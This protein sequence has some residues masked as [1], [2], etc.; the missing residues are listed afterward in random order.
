MQRQWVKSHHPDTVRKFVIT[1][2]A[3]FFSVTGIF[4]VAFGV[5]FGSQYYKGRKRD[6]Y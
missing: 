6:A 2:L 1:V 4:L 3:T 5:V